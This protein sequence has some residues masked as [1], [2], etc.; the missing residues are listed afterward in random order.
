MILEWLP[1]TSWRS[2][3]DIT[4]LLSA[5][6]I[7]ELII[8]ANIEINNLVDWYTRNKLSIHPDKSK[9]ILYKSPHFNDPDITTINDQI[10]LPIFI[11]LN[12]K[13]CPDPDRI[14]IT[15]IK[16]IKLVPNEFENSVKSL[17]IL[18]DDKLNFSEHI[19]K[20]HSKIAKS[21]L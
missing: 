17:G 15:K 13:P 6:N 7:N 4:G 8:K 18:L 14:D 1:L 21:N 16:L 20:L 10:Y 19:I 2:F 12:S 5:K 11:N 3:F 9:A